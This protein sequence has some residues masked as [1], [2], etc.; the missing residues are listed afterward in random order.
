MNYKI[1][2]D[3]VESELKQIEEQ[4][5]KLGALCDSISADV[6]SGLDSEN[7][8]RVISPTIQQVKDDLESAKHSVDRVRQNAY[9]YAEAVRKAD[10]EGSF[11]TQA[12]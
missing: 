6:S 3:A 1:E 9:A 5:N 12:G 4:I 10:T 11:N 7:A 2:I 8:R